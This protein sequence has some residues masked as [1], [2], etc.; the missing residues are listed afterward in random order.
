MVKKWVDY[1]K[2]KKSEDLQGGPK[3]GHTYDATAND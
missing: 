1:K 2:K 3:S